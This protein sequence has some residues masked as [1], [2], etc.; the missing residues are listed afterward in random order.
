[1]NF[2]NSSL[3]DLMDNLAK[4]CKTDDVWS[5]FPLTAATHP[6]LKPEAL[7]V[8]RR[9]RLRK[10]F[11]PDKSDCT[12]EDYMRWTWTLLLR[13]LP[14]PFD[15]MTDPMIWDK[16]PVWDM[17]CYGSKLKKAKTVEEQEAEHKLLRETAEVMGWTTFREIHD[18]YLHMDLCLADIMELGL[19]WAVC[20]SARQIAWKACPWGQIFTPCYVKKC[21]WGQIF[22]PCSVEICPWGQFFTMIFIFIHISIGISVNQREKHRCEKITCKTPCKNTLK[23]GI[24]LVS[25][26]LC[27]TYY[28]S[29]LR[30]DPCLSQK[31]H[32]TS[33]I[34]KKAC[35]N[36]R[37]FDLKSRLVTFGIL[38]W[39][40]MAP[41]FGCA[42][43]SCERTHAW[44]RKCT[45]R[46]G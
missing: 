39:R 21:P 4:T 1:M 3:G 25:V 45:E 35:K 26:C 46:V 16:K 33:W 29:F 6:E 32:R 12:E 13:K 28:L 31:M 40:R 17:S 11:A 5:V 7:T 14:M 37:N 30:A 10:Y 23:F 42:T 27:R 20:A 18:C 2:Y 44:V 24:A 19:L 22:T 36:T 15:H 41:R 8:G 34:G 43:V 38:P 9:V